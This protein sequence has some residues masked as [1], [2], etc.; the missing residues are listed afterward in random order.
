MISSYSFDLPYPV[1]TPSLAYTA[2][3]GSIEDERRHVVN[4]GKGC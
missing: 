2:T 1:Y 3:H 4:I